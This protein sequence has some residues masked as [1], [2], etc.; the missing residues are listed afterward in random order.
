MYTKLPSNISFNK[1][2]MCVNKFGKTKFGV[3]WLKI[4][5]TIR[6]HKYKRFQS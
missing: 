2:G 3:N 6:I 1:L 4:F 5:L